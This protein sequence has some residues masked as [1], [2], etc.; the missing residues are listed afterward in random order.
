MQ[1]YFVC[2][3]G[4]VG[5]IIFR[6]AGNV[7]RVICKFILLYFWLQVFGFGSA[8]TLAWPM[9]PFTVQFLLLWFVAR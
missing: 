3:C 2:C 7:L 8:G 1:I 4:P 6:V 9:T 5:S